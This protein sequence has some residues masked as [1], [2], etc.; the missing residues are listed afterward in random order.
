M[1]RKLSL[2]L[3]AIF[4]LALLAAAPEAKNLLKA[5]NVPANWRL[6]QHEQA[7]ASIAAEDDAI[8]IDVKET[9]GTDW[10]VQLTHPGLDLADGKEYTLSF[11]AKASDSRSVP[12]N[13]MI[14][15]EDW[16]QIGLS[17]TAEV[18][19]DWKDFSYDFKAD[20]TVK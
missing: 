13:A 1:S 6:E 10:H 19:K 7:K 16:H 20:Q 11:K 4:A 17:E 18:T 3:S 2:T 12:V 5:T 8:V 15:V 9:D 14:D